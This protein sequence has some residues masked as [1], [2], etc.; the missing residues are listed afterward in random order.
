M[1]NDRQEKLLQIISAKPIETQEQLLEDK[2]LKTS[3]YKCIDKLPEK[4]RIMLILR[5]IKEFSYDDIAKFTNTKLGTV[6][7]QINR[8]RLMLKKLLEKSGTFMDY[9][10]SKEIER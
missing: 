5:D 3:L 1:K 10:E 7:S 8:A 9:V 6:K 4:L 2:E